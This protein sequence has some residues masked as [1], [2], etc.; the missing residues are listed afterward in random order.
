MRLTGRTALI[1][2]GSRGLGAS[3][4]MDFAKE[5]AQVAVVFKSREDKATNVVNNIVSTGG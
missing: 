5:G 1:T 3:M 4:A 2:G